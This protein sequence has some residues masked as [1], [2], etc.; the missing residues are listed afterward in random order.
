MSIRSYLTCAGLLVFTLPAIAGA[1][2]TPSPLN[3]G[4]TQ[5]AGGMVVA[6][7]LA[8][9]RAPLRAGGPV[10]VSSMKGSSRAYAF[11]TRNPLGKMPKPAESERDVIAFLNGG[12]VMRWAEAT[13]GL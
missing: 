13:L 5:D 10:S 4:V 8:A 6:Q 2:P 9:R 1:G 3:A 7:V 11:S 12:T